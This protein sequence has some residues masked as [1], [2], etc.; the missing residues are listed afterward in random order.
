MVLSKKHILE[1]IQRKE[2]AFEPGLDGFQLQPHSV[3]L[4][5]GFDFHLPKTWEMTEEGRKTITI[6]PL[7]S[8]DHKSFEQ[9]NLKPGQYFELMPREYV[10]GTTMEKVVLNAPDLMAVL[11]PRSSINRRGL[12]VDLSGIIDVNYK[13]YL[14][15]PIMNNTQEQIIRVY[16]GERICTV[17][18][19]TISSNISLKD[20]SM[21]GLTKAKYQSNN[22]GFIGSKTD[23]DEEINLIRSGKISQLKKK[24]KVIVN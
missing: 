5:L 16:P 20:S 7:L 9:I 15:I 14:M 11:Y 6:D 8:G 22:Q 2:L 12:A 3:D 19:Q 24:F 18:F 17:V 13:G 23:K 21:H 1:R 4:R 10:V